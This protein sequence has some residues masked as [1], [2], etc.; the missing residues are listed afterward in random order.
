M[1]NLFEKSINL[2]LGALMYSRER[3]EEMVEELVNKG[4]IAQKDARQ[5]ASELVK[6]GEEEREE[7]KGLIKNEVAGAINQLNVAKK[8]DIVSKNEISEIVRDQILQVL[9]EQGITKKEEN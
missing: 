5:F 7:L 8:E 4:E 3:V 1:S 2:G 9:A 6:K